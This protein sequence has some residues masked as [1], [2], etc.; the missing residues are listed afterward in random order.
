[1]IEASTSEA[2]SRLDR[3]FTI[4]LWAEVPRDRAG[5]AGGLAAKF[6]PVSR[7]GFNLSAIS[8]AGGYNGPG[9]ELRVSFGIDAGSEPRWFDR[10]RPSPT[11]NYVSNSLTVF[12]GSLFAATSDA[13]DEADRGHVYRLLGETAWE[14]LGRVGREGAH[15]AGPLIVHR[16][17]LYAAT[18]NYDWTRVHDQDLEPCRVYRYDGPGRWEDC[19]QPGRSRRIFSL[20]S[21]RGDLLA[22]G[23]DSTVHGIAAGRR[24]SR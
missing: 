2:G 16:D 10:G 20:A 23:D 14:D 13:P 5:A 4:S 6:D 3:D 1:M 15:G 21:Y 18:W 11:S 7:T 12:D 24:G 19:G 9:D 8:S 22:F 17:A